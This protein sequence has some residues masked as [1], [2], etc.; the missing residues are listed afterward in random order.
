MS[1]EEIS[2]KIKDAAV[3]EFMKWGLDA[4]S[5]EDIAKGAQVSKRTLYKYYPTKEAVFDDM[6]LELVEVA[7][8]GPAIVYSKNESLESQVK[9]LVEKKAELLTSDEY[10]TTAR[11]VLSEV[12]KGKKLSAK[13]LAKFNESEIKFLKWIE[14]AKKDGKIKAK[15][16]NEVIADQTHAFI[17]GQLFYPVLFGMKKVTAND[18]KNIKKMTVEFFFKMFC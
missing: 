6:V 12:M 17:K 9:E 11:I 16:S 2:K 15:I 4:A 13:H 14:S 5:M 7:C 8:G 3:R 1:K 18:I 10:L